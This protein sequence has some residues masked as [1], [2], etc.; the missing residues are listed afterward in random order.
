MIGI[1]G[2]KMPDVCANCPCCW[3]W[4]NDCDEEHY[5]KAVTDK[6]P[7]VSGILIDYEREIPQDETYKKRQPWCPL[8]EIKEGG[9]QDGSLES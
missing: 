2:V 7:C 1:K 9:E 8:V 5:C 4:S 3:I 6:V